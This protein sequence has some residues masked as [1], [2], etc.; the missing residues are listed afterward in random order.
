MID[1]AVTIT[2][3]LRAPGAAALAKC[4]RRVYLSTKH[5][6][7]HTSKPGLLKAVYKAGNKALQWREMSISLLA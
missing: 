5:L 1:L 3:W 4:E 2:A 6:Q 7:G